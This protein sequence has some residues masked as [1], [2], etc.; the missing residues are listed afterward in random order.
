M[1]TPEPSADLRSP[2]ALAEQYVFEAPP[3]DDPAVQ[4][5]LDGYADLFRQFTVAEGLAQPDYPP[6]LARLDPADPAFTD[7]VLT[8]ARKNQMIGQYL[9]GN[10]Y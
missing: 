10:P 2:Q 7:R 1:P 3:E 5:A 8:S 9:L 4:E 6:L